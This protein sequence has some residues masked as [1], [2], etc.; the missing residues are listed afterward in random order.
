L[1]RE[2]EERETVSDASGY[3]R[4]NRTGALYLWKS[5]YDWLRRL[6]RLLRDQK[7]FEP[8]LLV[9]LGVACILVNIPGTGLMDGDFLGFNW[10]QA[11]RLQHS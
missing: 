4:S 8:F 3:G 1:G 2:A 10:C 11:D 9:P 5:G 6:V 7:K